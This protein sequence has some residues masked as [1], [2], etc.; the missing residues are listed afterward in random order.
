MNSSRPPCSA[1]RGHPSEDIFVVDQLPCMNRA[2]GAGCSPHPDGKWEA[3]VGRQPS[4]PRPKKRTRADLVR[5]RGDHIDGIG[6]YQRPEAEATTTTSAKP[7]SSPSPSTVVVKDWTTP[8]SGRRSTAERKQAVME[9]SRGRASVDPAR[10]TVRCAA[11]NRARVEKRSDRGDG[12][13]SAP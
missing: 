4:T 3:E 9:L 6:L 1:K 10:E 7:S 2:S 8:E 11:G 13:G 5:V 12:S